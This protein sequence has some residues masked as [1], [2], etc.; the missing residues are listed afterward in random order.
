MSDFW[1]DR[2]AMRNRTKKVRSGIPENP[3]AP[4]DGTGTPAAEHRAAQDELTA[5]LD[6]AVKKHPKGTG[7]AA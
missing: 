6:G 5:E 1:K 4:P 7:G 2:M 3:L